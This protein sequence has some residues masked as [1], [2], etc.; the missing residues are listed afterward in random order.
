MTSLSEESSGATASCRQTRG[1]G[2]P[3]QELA[4][5]VEKSELILKAKGNH[6]ILSWSITRSD[7]GFRKK[8]EEKKKGIRL[9]TKRPWQ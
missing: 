9:E 8:N 1:Q 7:L 6:W 3:T 4:G 2:Q 5:L